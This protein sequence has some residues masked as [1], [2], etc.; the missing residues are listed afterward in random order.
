KP[1][2][3]VA[4]MLPVDLPKTRGKSP[5][6]PEVPEKPDV[7]VLSQEPVKRVTEEVKLFSICNFHLYLVSLGLEYLHYVLI[8]LIPTHFVFC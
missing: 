3:G 5:I 8:L 1:Y 2:G 7:K 6:P 4:V